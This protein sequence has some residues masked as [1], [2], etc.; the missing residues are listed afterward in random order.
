MDGNEVQN[1][2]C[3]VVG[4]G[5]SGVA[6]ATTIARGG[7]RVL[8]IERGQYAGS[9]NMIGGAVFLTALKEIFPKTYETAPVE[10][11]INKHA[12]Q[13]L[14]QNS[15]VEVSCNFASC[16]KSFS[17]F[18]SKF[19]TWL[20]EQAKA[21][22]VY[23]APSTTVRSL[24]LKE[25]KVV[26]VKTDLEEIFAPV[27][28]L[29]DGVNSIL[30]KQIGLKE[31]YATKDIVL[32]VKETIKL[33]KEEI[34]KRFNLSNST[35]GAAINFV[36]GLKDDKEILN[37]PFAMGFLYTY[38]DTISIGL[39]VNLED[40]AEFEQ[41]PSVLLDKL[42]S[43]PCISPLIKD[44]EIIEYSAHMIPEGGYNKLPKLYANGALLVGDAA[45]F[46]NAIHFEG[47]NFALIS[48]KLAGEAVLSALNINDFSAKTLSVYNKKLKNSF[49]LKDLKSYKNVMAN[50]FSRT[51]SLVEY[52]PKKA[53]EFFE[54]FTGANCTPKRDSF[55][56]FIKDFIKGR[57]L[58]ELFSDIKAFLSCVIGVLK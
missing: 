24:I 13:L 1:F 16:P 20:V 15:S 28:V 18:R 10:R 4:A 37:A 34:E 55:R 42:K 53:A 17:T 30:A 50:L 8:L 27:V 41:N 31:E 45:G 48:G 14:S 2:D 9:K 26:G 12:W 23:F 35:S 3:I 36:G 11:Y 54:I 7:R 39:G 58:S 43:H 57:S 22:G 21:E 38:K 40:L 46:V 5:P 44:G 52:Y 33:S 56:K 29:A 6:C 25:D 51:E 47:T 32:A 49:I 19:D